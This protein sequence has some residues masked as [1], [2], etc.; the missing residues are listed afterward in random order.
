MKEHFSVAG[1]TCWF[2]G[3]PAGHG[4]RQGIRKLVGDTQFWA[5]ASCHH[6]EAGHEAEL[7]DADVEGMK[8]CLA[9]GVWEAKYWTSAGFI[10]Q[11]QE[12]KGYNPKFL[13]AL[14]ALPYVDE[15]AQE[16][17]T[18]QKAALVD[19]RKNYREGRK[20]QLYQQ[21][22]AGGGKERMAAL[23]QAKHAGEEKKPR[24]ARVVK[25]LTPEELEIKRLKA[26]EYSRQWYLARKGGGAELPPEFNQQGAGI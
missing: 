5:C 9:G 12:M 6:A 1:T 14:K 24:K 17:Q 11:V 15:Q 20:E 2:C 13:D 26:C 4:P 23:Y 25:V 7:R 22:H 19:Y 10:G 16:T 18:R 3:H 8:L 21:Y